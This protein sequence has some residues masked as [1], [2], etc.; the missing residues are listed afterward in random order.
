MK[1]LIAGIFFATSIFSFSGKY[2]NPWGVT[3]EFKSKTVKLTMPLSGTPIWFN[4][5]MDGDVIVLQDRGGPIV[6]EVK[7]DTLF[8]ETRRIAGYYYKSGSQ[9]LREAKKEAVHYALLGAIRNHN[10]EEVKQTLANGA[11]VNRAQSD[12]V[13][14]L[15]MA[16]VVNN[17][18]IAQILIDAGADVEKSGEKSLTPLFYAAMS[19]NVEMVELLIKAKANVNAIGP[20]GFTPLI[21]AAAG[22]KFDE[23]SNQWVDA[24][25]TENHVRVI[26]LLVKAKAQIKFKTP[27]GDT[28]MSIAKKRGTK[29]I[30]QA[31]QMAGA[32]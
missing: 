18:E 26:E 11:S 10:P 24:D 28:A 16:V 7:G 25:S 13:T 20:E 15:H 17:L 22:L 1:I 6:F 2:E 9:K 5:S 29:A 21:A 27:N 31:L 14:P 12:G 19:A 8:T 30:I 23:N 4:Y 3:L 32:E